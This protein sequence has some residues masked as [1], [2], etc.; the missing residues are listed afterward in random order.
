MN[1]PKCGGGAFLSDEELIKT[2]ENVKPLKMIVKQTYVCRA[3]AERFSRI[4]CDSLDGRKKAAESAP[5]GGM[6]M[7]SIAEKNSGNAGSGDDEAA[8]IQFLDRI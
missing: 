7:I 6:D 8:A 1:C 4:V 5:M 2:M 3:C